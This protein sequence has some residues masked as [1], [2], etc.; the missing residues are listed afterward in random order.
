MTAI[1]NADH[2]SDDPFGYSCYTLVLPAQESIKQLADR[3]E[4]EAGIT[5]AK[6][7]AHITVKGTFYGIDSLDEIKQRVEAIAA[8]TPAFT[9]PLA[10]AQS[11][12][13][14]QGGGLS[15]PVTSPLQALHDALVAAIAPLGQPAYQ[16][17]PYRPHMTY[18][19]DVSPAGLAAAK[20]RVAQTDFGPFFHAETVDLMGRI[21]PAHGGRWTLIASFPLRG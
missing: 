18:V 5:R 19:Q 10:G 7:P 8:R 6:I 4:Q 3:I 9:I 11:V 12:W 2:L 1:P 14:E 13:G 16:D 15:V 17:D 21:G 20:A